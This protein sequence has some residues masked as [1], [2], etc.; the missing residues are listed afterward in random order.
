M[1]SDPHPHNELK[2]ARDRQTETRR[3]MG[4]GG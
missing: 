4:R 2:A 1:A 3:T